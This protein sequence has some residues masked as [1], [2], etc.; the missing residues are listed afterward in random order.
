MK[1]SQVPYKPWSVQ[2]TSYII[3]QHSGPSSTEADHRRNLPAE[4]RVFKFFLFKTAVKSTEQN[5]V[6]VGVGII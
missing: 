2:V 3:L 6:C 4:V 1:T 5:S